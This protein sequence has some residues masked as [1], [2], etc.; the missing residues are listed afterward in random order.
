MADNVSILDATDATVVIATKDRSSVHYQRGQRDV[1]TVTTSYTRE[2]N[3]TAYAA[4]D[5]VSDS[6]TTPSALTFAAVARANAGSGRILSATMLDSIVPTTLGFF[7]LWLFVGTPVIPDSG[8]AF[9]D[10]VAFALPDVEMDGTNNRCV[11]VI[12]FA[13]WHSTGLGYFSQ[14]HGPEIP[15]ICNAS[16]DDL[17]GLV[18]VDNA[19]QSSANSNVLKF[20]L[21]IEQD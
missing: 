3:T 14:Y 4:G 2:A 13:A 8:A 15:F 17:W 20:W 6:A 21:E 16:N 19:Y 12:S 18:T 10:N 5:A 7:K 11:G 1:V 9:D